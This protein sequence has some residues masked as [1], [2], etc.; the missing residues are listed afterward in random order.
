MVRSLV[1]VQVVSLERTQQAIA[2]KPSASDY[3]KLMIELRME[4]ALLRAIGQMR[5]QTKR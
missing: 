5:R 4:L 3:D 2:V 1:A